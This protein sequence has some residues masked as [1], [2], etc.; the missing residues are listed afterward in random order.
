MLVLMLVV[1]LCMPLIPVMSGACSPRYYIHPLVPVT[2]NIMVDGKPAAGVRVVPEPAHP[3]EGFAFPEV[4]TDAQGHFELS[5]YEPKDGIPNDEYKLTFAWPDF[6]G[7]DRLH[8]RYAKTAANLT[9]FRAEHWH[10]VNLGTIR[11]TTK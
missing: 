1:A 9:T 11:L 6:A 3:V 2:G 7:N 8:G 4:L 5:T 10:P